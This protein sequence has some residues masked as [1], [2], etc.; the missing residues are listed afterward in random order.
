MQVNHIPL[1]YV[2][3]KGST[4][5]F[6]LEHNETGIDV[7]TFE[8][9]EQDPLLKGL[10]Y[11]D[12][13]E[14]GIDCA[15]YR[16]KAMDLQDGDV[17]VECRLDP[18]KLRSSFFDL[19][20]GTDYDSLLDL[21]Y[22]VLGTSGW[23]V[24]VSG[25]WSSDL[26]GMTLEESY[27]GSGLEILKAVHEQFG[28]CFQFEEVTLTAT[29]YDPYGVDP[30]EVP[31]LLHEE[32]NLLGVDCKGDSYEIVTRLYPRGV[33]ENDNPITI[34]SVNGG[35]EFID[36]FDYTS[37][38]YPAVWEY[39]VPTTPAGLL[40]AAKRHLRKICVPQESYR[41]KLM[42]LYRADPEKWK[43]YHFKVGGVAMY[44]D[45]IAKQNKRMQ[46]TKII[47]KSRCPEET[48]IELQYRPILGGVG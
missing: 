24:E 16:V 42:D 4:P 35:N 13:V 40:A 23:A 12:K 41:F 46:V 32:V 9:H 44:Y 7:L 31:V 1:L 8:T 26:D 47:E 17:K 2:N 14:A 20:L 37:I 25:A 33:D 10:K 6:T 34:A 36:C 28:V 30:N 27:T 48:E 22:A 21:I 18:F 15:S 45:R 38:V 11:E 5:Q 43:N 39:D 29:I 3:G 19:K